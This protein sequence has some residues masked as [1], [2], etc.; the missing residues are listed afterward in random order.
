MTSQKYMDM[1]NDPKIYFSL[2]IAKDLTFRV[3]SAMRLLIVLL[4]SLIV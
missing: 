4:Q 3:K 2:T 1:G